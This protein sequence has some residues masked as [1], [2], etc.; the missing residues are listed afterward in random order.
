MKFQVCKAEAVGLQRVVTYP[1]VGVAT[2]VFYGTDCFC[3]LSA[4][5][6][7]LLLLSAFLSKVQILSVVAA[8]L[9]AGTFIGYRKM[10]SRNDVAE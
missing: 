10:E 9:V 6:V 8:L 1:F 7:G 4:R 2:L 5:V 3:C